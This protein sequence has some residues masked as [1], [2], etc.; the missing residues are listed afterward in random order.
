MSSSTAKE[1]ALSAHSE[2]PRSILGIGALLAASG[3]FAACSFPE[4]TFD[5]QPS[6]DSGVDAKPDTVGDS[7]D[8]DAGK[9]DVSEK[10]VSEKDVSEKDV[11]EE[12]VSEKDVSEEDVSETDIATGDTGT[13]GSDASE[14]TA[15]DVDAAQDA[16]DAPLD[17]STD[18]PIVC[19]SGTKLCGGQCVNVADPSYGC[20]ATGCTACSLANAT[21]GCQG[22]ACVIASCAPGKADCDGVASNGCEETRSSYAAA[23]L[24]DS[25]VLY[26]RLS[27]SA[28]SAQ[29]SSGNGLH[30]TYLAAKL[31]EPGAL[32]CDANKAVRF[33]HVSQTHVVHERDPLLEPPQALSIEF[34]FKQTGTAIDWE[35]LIWYGDSTEAPWGSW[36]VERGLATNPK[37]FTLTLATD[38]QR[39]WL[40]YDA[41]EAD[42]W[43]HYVGTWNGSTMRVYVD[44]VLQRQGAATGTLKYWGPYGFAVGACMPP[45]GFFNGWIDE[46][47]IYDKALSTAR[48]AAHYTAGSP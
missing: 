7:S 48:I 1:R 24:A 16:A 42:T 29:D 8:E 19:G 39:Y 28:G 23:V 27:D 14:D 5:P 18:G 43:Y 37:L 26:W 30:G 10:D 3:C 15:T 12:D 32:Y 41:F 20:T 2:Y 22:G 33:T 36:G 13:D 11:S 46:V 38:V 6:S 9:Q 35:K 4:V 44:G 47:A 21:A 45:F 31:N 34:W 17:T 40:D 25:P